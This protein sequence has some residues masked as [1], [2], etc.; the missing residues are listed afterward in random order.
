MTDPEERPEAPRETSLRA[1][2]YLVDE[3]ILP[4]RRREVY[5]A[6][7]H[8]GPGTSAEMFSKIG[9]FKSNH[10]PITS[11]RSRF[12]ELRDM[13]LFKEVGTRKC[14]V[15]GREA[16]VWDVTSQEEPDTIRRRP[17]GESVHN[18][19]VLLNWLEIQL[20]ADLFT[21]DLASE[22]R[23]RRAELRKKP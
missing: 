16:I 4:I 8:H 1:Y 17:G 13:G 10:T 22:L 2:H 3:G 7:F 14:T 12:T 15:T 11:S 9:E 21:R 23:A 18:Y 5:E 20:S 6:L 19:R